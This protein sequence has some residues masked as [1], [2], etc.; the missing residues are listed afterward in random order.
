MAR[1]RNL[2]S[3]NGF[4][5]TEVLIVVVVIMLLSAIFIPSYLKQR[6][7]ARDAVVKQGV[8]SIAMGLRLYNLDHNGQ[9]PLDISGPSGKYP[10]VDAAGTAYLDAW[11]GNPWTGKPM[12]NTSGYSEGDF[13][14]AG[15]STVAAV[16]LTSM[17]IDRCSLL[18]WVSS[19]SQPFVASEPG[20]LTVRVDVRH[21][22]KS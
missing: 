14:Y 20:P 17:E 4:T 10:L 3:A 6:D 21:N 15:F 19:K 16:Q 11:P 12:N 9:Y 1:Q 7:R 2:E 5:F 18:G 13:Q 22:Q 8:Q